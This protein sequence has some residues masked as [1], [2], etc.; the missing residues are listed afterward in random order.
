QSTA[1]NTSPSVHNNLM[2]RCNQLEVWLVGRVEGYV[3]DQPSSRSL[4][5]PDSQLSSIRPQARVGGV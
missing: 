3:I 1:M 4:A 2:R 5:R